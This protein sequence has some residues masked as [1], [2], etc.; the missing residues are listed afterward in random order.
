MYLLFHQLKISRRTN[1]IP[2]YFQYFQLELKMPGDLKYTSWRCGHPTASPRDKSVSVSLYKLQPILTVYN[3][4]MPECRGRL[5]LHRAGPRHKSYCGPLYHQLHD[6]ISMAPLTIAAKLLIGFEK[7]Y[8]GVQIP[9]T[10][11]ITTATMI[12]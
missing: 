4:T 8:R 3:S 10:S 12:G 7:D 6:Y 11:S 9:R 2:G 1:D 5:T